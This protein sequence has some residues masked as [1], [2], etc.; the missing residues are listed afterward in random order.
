MSGAAGDIPLARLFA[1]A[2]RYF[3]DSLHER[4]R[5]RGWGDVRPA[6][7]FALL[8]ARD[9][10]TSATEL[11]S[12]MGTSKQAASKLAAVMIES[13]YLVQGTEAGDGRQRPLRLSPRGGRLLADVESIY[14]EIEAEWAGVIGAAALGRL[15]RSLRAAI[16]ASHAGELP[17]VRP[18][19]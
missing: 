14:E 5:E 2:Y 1:M 7:G 4:L 19:W 13:G 17:A 8:A 16:V 11:A 3:V 15:R 10:P 12:L 18:T 9:A 6:Y